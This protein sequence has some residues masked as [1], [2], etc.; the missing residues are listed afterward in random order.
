MGDS[1][2]L[3]VLHLP[4]HSNGSIAL[5]DEE[6]KYI[7]TGD[8]IYEDPFLIDC[9]PTSNFDDTIRTFTT[10]KEMSTKISMV[11]PGHDNTFNGTTLNYICTTYINQ[12]SICHLCHVSIVKNTLK[13][14]LLGRNLPFKEAPISNCCYYYG[15]CCCSCYICSEYC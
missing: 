2:K 5:Y 6:R 7:F 8:I 11:F 3:K 15:C 4:G 9:G 10:L 13:C 14:Y 12:M 1:I